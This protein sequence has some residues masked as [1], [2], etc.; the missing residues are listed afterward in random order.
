MGRVWIICK[1]IFS[2]SLVFNALVTI[3][4]TAGISAVST[5]TTTTGSRSHPTLS[6]ATSSGLQSQPPSSTSFPAQ[7]SDVPFTRAVS[8]PPLLLRHPGADFSQIYVAFFTPV[9]LLSIFLVNDTSV[10]VNLGR[11]FL[12]GGLTLVLDDLPDVS[13]RIESSLNG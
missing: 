2:V 5:G 6:A 11:F 13:K 12:L 8:V 9:T 10:Q 7:D 3:G 1:K 4:C